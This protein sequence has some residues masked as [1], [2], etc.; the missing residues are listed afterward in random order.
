MKKGKDKLN[1]ELE[2]PEGF[3]YLGKNQ[4]RIS[5]E[6]KKKHITFY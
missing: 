6:K 2:D 4:R 1:Y 3:D 5:N